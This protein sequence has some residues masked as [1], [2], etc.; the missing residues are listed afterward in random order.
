MAST[1]TEKTFTL[2][3]EAVK[4]LGRGEKAFLLLSVRNN[5]RCEGTDLSALL[6]MLLEK[7]K[8]NTK[9]ASTGPAAV[10]SITNARMVVVVVD[11]LQKYNYI[12]TESKPID[13]KTPL[14]WAR[15][16]GDDYIKANAEFMRKALKP[17]TTPVPFSDDPEVIFSELNTIGQEQGVLFLRWDA[18]QTEL[19]K[20]LKLD[21]LE[22]YT[23]AFA[24]KILAAYT[25]SQSDKTA[26]QSVFCP[27]MPEDD[28]EKRRHKT[29]TTYNNFVRVIGTRAQEY[30]AGHRTIES[31]Q[32]EQIANS[33]RFQVEEYATAA[34]LTACKDT[35]P[36]KVF[37]PGKMIVPRFSPEESEHFQFIPEL[38]VQFSPWVQVNHISVAQE[39][40]LA[41]KRARAGS[42]S[43]TSLS[44]SPSSSS[45]E[46][47]SPDSNDG[48]IGTY[49]IAAKKQHN[50]RASQS[51]GSSSD[52]SPVGS[53][54]RE[55][56]PMHLSPPSRH[57]TP[58]SNSD[59]EIVAV[60]DEISLVVDP[61]AKNI[62]VRVSDTPDGAMKFTFRRVG[63][64]P[65]PNSFF[66]AQ[67]DVVTHPARVPQT[68]SP[69][70][71]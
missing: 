46:S 48:E 53:P 10:L 2:P 67:T 68:Q 61:S 58:D 25:T 20:L 33:I 44:S 71:K 15:K 22:K 62:Q 47:G 51:S 17:D 63:G 64:N 65:N 50:R 9:N 3:R 52:N 31:P 55:T 30:V 41:I 43:H 1:R 6:K 14:D 38:E 34:A 8:A 16:A 19:A 40:G 69:A 13:E 23:S 21:S 70:C 57:L 5:P 39:Q 26:M 59:D 29:V 60:G 11:S 54:P 66:K 37:Y 24:E 27:S 35:K 28:S 36:H 45:V 7:C 12:L 32:D 42:A 18:F 4:A 56:S 49:L